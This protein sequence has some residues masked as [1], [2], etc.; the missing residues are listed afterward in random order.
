LLQVIKRIAARIRRHED[1]TAAYAQAYA[2]YFA[3]ASRCDTRAM[4]ELHK[5]LVKAMNARL[6][7]GV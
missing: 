2:A 1:P 3:A 7:A 4:H 5:P 6:R